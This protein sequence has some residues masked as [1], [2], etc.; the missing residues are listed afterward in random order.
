MASNPQFSDFEVRQ[1]KDENQRLRTRNAAL[2]E[3]LRKHEELYN[4]MHEVLREY[5][6]IKGTHG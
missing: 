2:E 3:R 1:L 6:G 4:K 5:A